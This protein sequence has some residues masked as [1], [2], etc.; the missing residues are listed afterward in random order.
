MLGADGPAPPGAAT[1]DDDLA[2]ALVDLQSLAERL[3]RECPWDRAQT[4]KTIVPHTLEEAYEVAE[5]ALDGDDEKLLDE[6]GDLLFQTYFL[7][8]LVSERGGGDLADVARRIHAKLVRRHPH[9]F[10]AGDELGS[11]GAVK[12]RWEALKTS[13]EDREG[14]FHHV[15]RTLPALLH[16]RKVQRRAAG[17]GFDYPGVAGCLADLEDELGELEDELR[18]RDDPAP[19][20]E[21]DERVASEVGDVLFACVNVARRLN[22]DP[23]L[24][25]RRASDRFVARVEEAERLARAEGADFA[26]LPLTEQD[27]LFDRAK[28]GRA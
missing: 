14:I 3:R 6:L 18:G 8:L 7:S 17:V 22:V 25:L 5:A 2:Q 27:R 13:Q 26:A 28:E 23:E 24:E 19:E 11:A 16:A 12:E 20:T 1:R 15:P 21:P 9:V 4:E 10:E